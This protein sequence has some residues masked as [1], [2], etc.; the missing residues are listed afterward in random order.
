MDTS[1]PYGGRCLKWGVSK[2]AAKVVI[3][4]LSACAGC[5][6]AI[7]DL[8]EDL[9]KILE[10]I[11]IVHAPILMDHK[12][13]S[14]GD[15]QGEIAVPKGDIGILS[16]SIRTEEHMEVARAMRENCDILI[17]NGSCACFGGVSAIANVLPLKMLKEDIYPVTGDQENNE[18]RLPALTSR[19]VA[20]N[21]VMEVDIF[22]PGC[23]P[24]TA[25][26]MEAI[27][28]ILEDRPFQLPEDT[29][30]NECPKTKEKKTVFADRGMAFPEMLRPLEPV[31]LSQRCLFEQGY[32]C[33][34]A[35]TRNGC[36]AQCLKADMPCRGCTGPVKIGENPR[37]ELLGSLSLYGYTLRDIHDKRA[38]FNWFTGAHHNLR[39]IP[40]R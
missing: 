4:S 3:E 11:E 18:F 8:G 40:T 39:P 7:L 33:M 6:V 34:G 9:L 15:G 31:P 24:P 21:E 5:E 19:V 23:P 27:T 25:L 16:G 13:F 17:A 10:K 32:F 36:G 12:H 35:A 1:L 38:G 14:P 20:L 29:V 2:V 28:A 37:A 26:F 30:C 22:I